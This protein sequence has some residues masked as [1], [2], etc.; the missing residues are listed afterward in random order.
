VLCNHQDERKVVHAER[1]IK[2]LICVDEEN[3]VLDRIL[4]QVLVFD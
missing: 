4:D 1:N 3:D 2:E